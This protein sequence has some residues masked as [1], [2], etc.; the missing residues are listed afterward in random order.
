LVLLKSAPNLFFW[1]PCAPPAR[2]R[3]PPSPLGVGFDP[4][5]RT[6][7][8]SGCHPVP[9]GT[10]T[11]FGGDVPI[12]RISIRVFRSRRPPPRA[13][14]HLHPCWW[15]QGFGQPPLCWVGRLVAPLERSVCRKLG[16]LPV[17]GSITSAANVTGCSWERALLHCCRLACHIYTLVG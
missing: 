10:M 11:Q 17:V 12:V 1:T 5:R 8:G 3:R 2:P 15:S 14:G 13:S 16:F 4:L 7:G 9:L 6:L